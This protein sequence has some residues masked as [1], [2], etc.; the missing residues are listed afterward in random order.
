MLCGKLG[1]NFGDPPPQGVVTKSSS[2]LSGNVSKIDVN[3]P[4]GI[5][6]VVISNTV[7]R[8]AFSAVLIAEYLNARGVNLATA[9]QK[10]S[11]LTSD[12]PADFLAATGGS[13]GRTNI[14]VDKIL[15]SFMWK[16]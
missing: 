5:T 2:A 12:V 3:L 16:E 9:S 11:S 4:D 6:D 14:K 7:S 13:R 10:H 8:P 1:H 15:F